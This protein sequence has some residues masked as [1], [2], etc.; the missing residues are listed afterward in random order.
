MPLTTAQGI[1]SAA[2]TFTTTNGA[3]TITKIAKFSWLIPENA[4][5]FAAAQSFVNGAATQLSNG[6]YFV[7]QVTAA[8]GTVNYSRVDVTVNSNIATL[9]GAVV[10]GQIATLGTASETLG[11]ETAGIITLTTAQ[12]TG[13]AATTFTTTNGAATITKIAKFSSGTTVNLSDFGI[14]ITHFNPLPEGE[15]NNK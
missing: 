15:I 3:A 8:D 1:G 11:S 14:L 13:S 7:I 10:K 6:D 4:S 5:N 9:S 2:T 12:A